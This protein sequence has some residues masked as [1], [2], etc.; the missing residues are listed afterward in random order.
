MTLPSTLFS[1]S[2]LGLWETQTHAAAM[3]CL[4]QGSSSIGQYAIK[5]CTLALNLSWNSD[6][7]EPNGWD[8]S[9]SLYIIPLIWVGIHFRERT[10]EKERSCCFPHLAPFLLIH[11][12]L[13]HLQ[14]HLIQCTALSLEERSRKLSQVC[15]FTAVNTYV[16]IVTVV[17]A[18][19]LCTAPGVFQHFISKVFCDHLSHSILVYL[20]D[21][22]IFSK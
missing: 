10:Q 19:G 1:F 22:L 5:F 6:D 12:S 3:I 2:W 13:L 7:L 20:E 15:V 21:I 14:C 9:S 4:K 8:I 17:M 16:H 11:Q 18:S